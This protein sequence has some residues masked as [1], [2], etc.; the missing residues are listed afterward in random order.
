VL[1][2]PTSGWP[3]PEQIVF[4]LTALGGGVAAFYSPLLVFS[5]I[6]PT[7]PGWAAGL[8]MFGW[9]FFIPIYLA[10]IVTAITLRGTRGAWLCLSSVWLWLV[11]VGTC[12]QIF[13][14]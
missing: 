3:W 9:A 1:G 11:I 12:H 14:I 13:V 4:W 5:K 10:F 7:A 8:I 6:S 2:K